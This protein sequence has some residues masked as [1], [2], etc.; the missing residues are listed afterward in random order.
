MTSR[1]LRIGRDVEV[2]ARSHGGVDVEGAIRLRPGQ[3]VDLIEPDIGVH[4]G[5][6]RRAYVTSWFIAR[7]GR[8]GPTYGGHCAWQ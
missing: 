4:R 6:V 3:S 1:R 2:V 8:D 7:L 5:E